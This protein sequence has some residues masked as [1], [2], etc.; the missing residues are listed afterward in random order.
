MTNVATEQK[1]RLMQSRTGRAACYVAMI[2][3]GYFLFLYRR[4]RIRI[5]PSSIL[6]LCHAGGDSGRNQG[7]SRL[8]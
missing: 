1:A 8:I 7:M 2:R 6:H 5:H 4:V 3:A